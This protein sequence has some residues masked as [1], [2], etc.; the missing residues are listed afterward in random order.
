ML[1]TA[2][3]HTL[4]LLPTSAPVDRDTN[5]SRPIPRT[6]GDLRF[7]IRFVDDMVPGSGLKEKTQLDWLGWASKVRDFPALFAIVDGTFRTHV[8]CKKLEFADR[9]PSMTGV[10]RH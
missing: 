3:R 1:L 6:P 10:R 9:S 8:I 2:H 4:E 7:A 5:C